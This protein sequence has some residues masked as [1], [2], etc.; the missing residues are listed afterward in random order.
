[1]QVRTQ[2]ITKVYN[3]EGREVLSL[4]TKSARSTASAQGLLT[5]VTKTS[6]E[7]ASVTR[8]M[9]GAVADK[10]SPGEPSS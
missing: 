9:L 8:D 6:A 7:N 4:T 1:M 10:L 5:A 3:E 2:T